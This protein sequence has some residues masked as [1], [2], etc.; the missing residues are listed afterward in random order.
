MEVIDANRKAK[1][2]VVSSLKIPRITINVSESLTPS[3]LTLLA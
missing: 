3:Q 1:D 2:L